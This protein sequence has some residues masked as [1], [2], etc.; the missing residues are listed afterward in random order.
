MDST[1]QKQSG[2][3]SLPGE[4]RNIIYAY[5]VPALEDQYELDDLYDLRLE[6]FRV[7]ISCFL[8]TCK[9]IYLEAK[10]ILYA[11]ATIFTEAGYISA[12]DNP[13]FSRFTVRGVDPFR[14]SLV[15][16]L[17]LQL[18]YTCP[19]CPIRIC[20]GIFLKDC[21]EDLRNLRVLHI[22]FSKASENTLGS[23]AGN[24]RDEPQPLAEFAE[25]NANLRTIKV[26]G[27]YDKKW[28][29]GLQNALEAKKSKARLLLLSKA[30]AEQLLDKPSECQKRI[31]RP[32]GDSPKMITV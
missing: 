27:D 26:S 9:Q 13:S 25:S 23:C 14:L 18:E 21:G 28:L 29:D 30:E 12:G 10:P 11:F 7:E 4:I 5:C 16:D 15:R 2:F 31:V 24:L 1:L 17:Q 32:F 6:S 3:F 19:F 20:L 8:R 22:H